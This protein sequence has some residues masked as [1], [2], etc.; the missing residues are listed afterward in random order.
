MVMFMSGDDV[1]WKTTEKLRNNWDTFRVIIHAVFI[2][3]LS[4]RMYLQWPQ[5]PWLD[6][7][8]QEYT[9]H[10]SSADDVVVTRCV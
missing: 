3:Q 2:Y 1:T 9:Y 8:E 7:K 5:L 4:C 10:D 6:L